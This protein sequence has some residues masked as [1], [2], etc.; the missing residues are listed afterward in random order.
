MLQGDEMLI[1]DMPADWY[2]AVSF[3]R[4]ANIDRR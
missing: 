2:F 1:L 4:E 3:R